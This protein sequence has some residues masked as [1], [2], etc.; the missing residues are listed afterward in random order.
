MQHPATLLLGW[1]SVLAIILGPALLEAKPS[2]RSPNFIVILCDDLGYG[3]LGCYGSKSIATPRLDRMAAEGIRCT[4]FYVTA[5]ICSPSRASLLTGRYAQRAG[6]PFVLFPTER[7]GL[8]PAE[9]TIAEMLRSRHYATACIGKWH[10]GFLPPFQPMNQGFD[11]FFGLPYS[12]DSLKQPSDSPFNPVLAPVDLPLLRGTNILEAPANQET[13]TERYTEEAIRFIRDHAARP[14]FLY[15]PHTF[16]HTPLH[17]S[18]KFR[19]RSR[20]SLYGDTVEAI[21]WSVGQL[22]D[23]LAKL[24]IADDTLVVFTSDNGPS[25]VPPKTT[26]GGG[27]SG[28]FRAGKFTCYEGGFRVPAIF[29]WPGKIPAGQVCSGITTSMDL[30]PTFAHLAQAKLPADRAL[31]GKN[32]WP[33]LL[34]KNS[35]SPHE[36]FFYYLDNQL[37]AIRRGNFKLFLPQSDYPKLTTIFYDDRPQALPKHF[38]LRDKPQLFDLASDPNETTDIADAH[39]A[40]VKQLVKRAQAFDRKLQKNKRPEA[41]D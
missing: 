23:E 16:P 35:R 4:S 8:A 12:N 39:P 20:G 11:Y 30:F 36:E 34:A 27:S 19:G 41:V 22:L 10:L 14:F 29:W 1:L 38:P 7:K 37:Q 21:D 2:Q 6:M 3:D 5:P 31:D 13:L 33:W 17:V 24:K 25:P 15:L 9:I 28:G 40:A 18:E 32:L 26:R